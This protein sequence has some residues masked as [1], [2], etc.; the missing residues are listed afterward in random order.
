MVIQ[1]D[2]PNFNPNQFESIRMTWQPNGKEIK[3][4]PKISLKNT[5]NNSTNI[6]LNDIVNELNDTLKEY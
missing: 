1:I 2:D 5:I 6:T 4:S 3:D